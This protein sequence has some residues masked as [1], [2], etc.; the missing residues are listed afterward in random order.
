MPSTPSQTNLAVFTPIEA[1]HVAMLGGSLESVAWH[2]AGI[3][4]PNGKAITVPQAPE[5]M[6]VLERE[7]QEKDASL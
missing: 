4:Q 7:A 3:I 1:E 2:K 5:V 6:A